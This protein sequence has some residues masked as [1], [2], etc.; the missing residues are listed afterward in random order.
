MIYPVTIKEKNGEIKR[1]ISSASLKE[2]N[3]AIFES[4]GYFAT[5]K[6]REDKC[7][8]L[9]CGKLFWT[10]Q[11]LKKYCSKDCTAI[12]GRETALKTKARQKRKRENKKE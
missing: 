10:K 1:V 4:G 5:N 2:R 6:M 11:P 8:R 12:V 3:S 9:E 7:D